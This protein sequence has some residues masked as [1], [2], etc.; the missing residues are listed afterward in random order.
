MTVGEDLQLEIAVVAHE[1]GE[2]RHQ[3]D[4]GEMRRHIDLQGGTHPRPRERPCRRQDLVEGAA[5]MRVVGGTR[6]GQQHLAADPQKQLVP[7]EGLQ[8]FDLMADR[9]RGEEQL[10]G[11]KGE[12]FPARRHLEATKRRQRWQLCFHRSLGGF[13]HRRMDG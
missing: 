2:A 12:A 13:R 9:R 7:E 11:R 6:I 10:V 5:D 8:G 1:M 3:P 4:G